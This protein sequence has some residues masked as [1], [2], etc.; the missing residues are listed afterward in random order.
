MSRAWKDGFKQGYDR[1]DITTY[2]QAFIRAVFDGFLITVLIWGPYRF[3]LRLILCL[4]ARFI[5]GMVASSD[6][7]HR[8]L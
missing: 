2:R 7:F 4:S 1:A 6:R 3:W 8:T 5:Y